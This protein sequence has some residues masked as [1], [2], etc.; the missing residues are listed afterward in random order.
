MQ[1]NITE[2]TLYMSVRELAASV[3]ARRIS[4]VALAEAYIE[5]LERLGPQLGAVVTVTRDLAMK[6][7]SLA[8]REIRAGRYRG[9]LHGIPYG[10]KDLIATEKIPTTWG[11]EP[12]RNQVFDY[13]AT[14]VKK[15][16]AAGAVLIAKLSMVELAGGFGYNNADASFTGPGITPWNK[17][18]WSGGSSSGPGSA[19][20][21]ALAAFS[22][23]SET[24]GSIITP[25]AFCGVSGL[26]PTYG[27]VSRHGA[28]ALSWTLD[29]LGPMCRTA[30]DCGL[31]LA[32]IS[33]QD[34]LDPTSVDARFTYPD[35]AAS[36]LV[37]ERGKRWRI[38]VIKGSI[39]RAQPEVKKNFEESLKVLS[40]FAEVVEN[41]VFPNMPFG[42]VVGTIVSAEGASAFRDLVES[43]E[44]TKL[45]AVNDRWGGYARTM[46]LAV[47]YL[48]AMRVRGL[49]KREMDD[50]YSKFDALVSPSRDTVS[51]PLAVDF[52]RAYPGLGGGPPV[53]PAGNAVGQ[54]A[55]SI[56]NGFGA[57]N[58]P[59]GI[60]FTGRVWSEARLLAI[61]DAYQK[62]TDWHKKRPPV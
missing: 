20:A 62:A 17:D 55:I 5:R 26:R 30:D 15:L 49:M 43:G 52:N 59:T 53:I 36:T 44:A 50:A 24:S 11:A 27:R 54:P 32:A 7:A 10:V 40:R 46:V 33:G 51:Y 3:R 28:M 34:P 39:D 23:G 13:D 2:E 9:P 21:A 37:K 4:P 12:Y 45:R 25:S 61:A 35:R 57:N 60:Q 42:P 29:K 16:R 56:P 48:Q 58:L 6:E 19:T 41:V 18:Y 1:K 22:I 31:V 8:E 47:D 38:G 14:I